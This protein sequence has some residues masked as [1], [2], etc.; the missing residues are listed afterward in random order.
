MAQTSIVLVHDHELFREGVRYHVQAS[1]DLQIVA[2]AS[3]GQ[4]AIQQVEHHE[5]DLLLINT[6]LPG[7]SGLEVA[8]VVKRDHPQI[9]VVLIGSD[10]SPQHIIKV[11]RSGVAAY[12]APNA[13][14]EHML[15]TLRVVNR[16]GYPVNELVLTIPHVAEQ[17]LDEFRQREIDRETQNFYSPLSPRELQ[18]LELIARGQT[19]KAIAQSLDISNQTVKNHVSSI[20]RKLAVNGRMQAVIYALR[21]GW[22]K[23]GSGSQGS[24]SRAEG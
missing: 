20:L 16:G 15:H 22:I 23:D 8:W 5:P 1:P 3:N 10:T 9:G 19:N 21:Q 6:D 4:Q 17:V 24:F 7:I 13:S 11:I 18:V 12:V 2:E 14:W